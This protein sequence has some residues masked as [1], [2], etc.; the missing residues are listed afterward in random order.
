[1]KLYLISFRLQQFA[2]YVDLS[3]DGLPI[4]S[5]RLMDSL[6]TMSSRQISKGLLLI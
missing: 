1:M 2:N 3:N 5:I 6:P 4:T